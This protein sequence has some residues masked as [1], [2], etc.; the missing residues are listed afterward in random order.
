MGKGR[1]GVLSAASLLA[2]RWCGG[3][4]RGRGRPPAWYT[5][6]TEYYRPRGTQTGLEMHS[7]TTLH[8]TSAGVV[9]ERTRTQTR[10]DIYRYV[11]INIYKQTDR[12]CCC[13]PARV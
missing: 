4:G 11:Y 1:G 9:R 8:P 6:H 7:G 5:A 10:R 3:G 13:Q 12:H 2:G